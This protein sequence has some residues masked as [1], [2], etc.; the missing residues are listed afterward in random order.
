VQTVEVRSPTNTRPSQ[1]L[2]WLESGWHRRSIQIRL[3]IPLLLLLLLSLVGT[4]SGFIYSTNA[5]RD[6][7]LKRQLDEDARQIT[8]SI[9]HSESDALQS[10]RLLANVL[11]DDLIQ[12]S[13]Y[14][15]NL[16][17]EMYDKIVRVRDRF[18]LDQVIVLNAEG[19][20]RANI[21]GAPFL[22]SIAVR[23]PE[24]LPACSSIEEQLASYQGTTL[25]IACAPVIDEGGA[26]ESTIELGHV[27]TVLDL[28]AL[29]KRIR[30]SLELASQPRL[31]SNMQYQQTSAPPEEGGILGKLHSLDNLHERT[32][33]IDLGEER[34]ALQ[35]TFDAQHIN[36]IVTSGLYVMVASSFL[37]I[38]LS[39]LVALLSI[40]RLLIAPL[41]RLTSVAEQ[42]AAG[43]LTARAPVESQDEIGRLATTFNDTTGEL[44][45]L[46]MKLEQRVEQRTAEL[47][48]TNEH[49]LQEIME[50]KRAEE[51][52][53]LQKQELQRL[54]TVDALT[55]LYNRRHFFELGEHEILLAQA[56]ERQLTAIMLDI[57][58]F[59]HINDTYGH[60]CGD[61]VLRV[62][63]QYC[64]GSIRDTD[65]VGRYGG[66]EFA[67]LLPGA[68][69][70]A[71]FA[72][73]ERLRH[74]VE[75][76]SIDTDRGPISV[77]ISMGIATSIIRPGAAS[78]DAL[79][80]QA[81]KAL[82]RAKRAG[83]NCVM[84]AS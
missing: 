15:E 70:Q 66:E 41:L 23:N 73:A 32:V 60:A 54:A 12:E 10:A 20:V 13:I 39:V 16:A 6:S 11:D 38:L 7:I 1:P 2:R 74:D 65:I 48:N 61:Q 80:D 62:V 68:D 25:L 9:H 49:L 33:S 4:T 84:Q 51:Q 67:I 56:N 47:M 76:A 37:A 24:L 22:E 82:Y 17:L 27:Y 78:L 79:L 57:D 42:V 81:D 63:A 45:D 71:A 34:I 3:L 30:R 77:T 46:V 59:K 40:R 36:E 43:D 8:A 83:R 55:N 35:L 5:T 64:Q 72:I 21:A 44:Y 52:I 58:H 19:Y 26:G 75:H 29:L 18:G 31:V 28:Q 69:S 53:S 14:A 50:R